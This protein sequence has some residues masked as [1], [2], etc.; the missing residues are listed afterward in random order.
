MAYPGLQLDPIFAHEFLDDPTVLRTSRLF[1]GD[2]CILVA[3]DA[4]RIESWTHWHSDTPPEVDYRMMKC[5]MYLDEHSDGYGSVAVLPG[6]HH[7]GLASRAV[8]LARAADEAEEK[9]SL[10]IINKWASSTSP[11]MP[12]GAVTACTRP[13][14]RTK[15][16][17]RPPLLRNIGLSLWFESLALAQDIVYFN[18]RLLHSS[19][20]GQRGRR[21]LGLTLGEAPLTAPHIAHMEDHGQR[22]SQRCM[23]ARKSQ[24]PD[25]VVEGAGPGRRRLIDWL[26]ERGF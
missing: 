23:N 19:W 11:W 5:I 1:L 26:L 21:F 24:V 20:G 22:W 8:P 25:V 3:S 16:P 15:R 10:G 7:F 18:Q 13:G 17:A 2:D 9:K 4:Q 14:V 12:P 6:S